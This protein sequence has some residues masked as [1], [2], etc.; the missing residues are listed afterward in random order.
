VTGFQGLD[1]DLLRS[2]GRQAGVYADTVDEVRAA[3]SAIAAECMLEPLSL[4]VCDE[5]AEEL[6]LLDDLCAA[7]ATQMEM[8]GSGM[9]LFDRVASDALAKLLLSL[10]DG[11]GSTGLVGDN[12]LASV[13][14]GFHHLD[15]NQNGVVTRDELIAAAADSAIPI[16]FRMGA[17]YLL[18]NEG[19][20]NNAA[21]LSTVDGILPHRSITSAGIHAVIAQN[22]ILR[23]MSNPDVFKQM[24]S[25]ANGEFD[26]RLSEG[27]LAAILASSSSTQAMRDVARFLTDNPRAFDWFDTGSTTAEADRFGR[28]PGGMRPVGDGIMTFD[29]VLALTVGQHAFAAD[30]AGA[31]Q[32][33]LSLANFATWSEVSGKQAGIDIRLSSDDGLRALAAA[34]LADTTTLAEQVAVVATLP[35]SRGGVRNQLITFYYA[36]LAGQMNDRLNIDIDAFDVTQPGHSGANWMQYAPWAS[37]S[38]GPAIRAEITAYG[39]TPSWADRQY[40]ADGNQYIFGDVALRYASFLAAFPAGTPITEASM[41]RFFTGNHPV[42]EATKLFQPGH[43]ELRDSFAYYLAAI[44]ET[45][46]EL[47]Q[48]RTMQGNILI[49]I[50]EQAGAQHALAGIVDLDIG[51]DGVFRGLIGEIGAAVLEGSDEKVATNRTALGIGFDSDQHPLRTYAMSDD[52]PFSG[53]P[54]TNLILDDSLTSTLNTHTRSN[55]DVGNMQVTFARQGNVGMSGDVVLDPLPGWEEPPDGSDMNRFPTDVAEWEQ[56]AGF[57]AADRADVAEMYPW[58]S[59]PP[60]NYDTGATNWAD[61]PDRMWS[62]VNLFQQTHTDPLLFDSLGQLT[63]DSTWAEPLA[64]LP[65]NV[66]STRR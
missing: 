37:N 28:G 35:E 63:R 58:A 30:P 47:R 61:A 18:D 34:A 7:K 27:D 60:A 40:A 62:I 53:S 46:P 55:I 33:T 38:V 24:E 45:D 14:A 39:Q 9:F 48:I 19:L 25:A 51:D 5:M 57:T 32:F 1:P 41:S 20:A 56:D 16:E 2:L 64:Y 66:T 31:R 49:A 54:A 12:A 65:D 6:R 13:L 8:A 36:E 59:P 4:P 11:N 21:R 10:N 23:V 42:L 26:G 52:V 44:E 17:K 22:A 3:I 29:D 50:H 43:R 15:A